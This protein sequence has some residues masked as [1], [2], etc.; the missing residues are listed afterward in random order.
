MNGESSRQP[1]PVTP[2]DRPEQIQC[3]TCAV[4]VVLAAHGSAEHSP[5]RRIGERTIFRRDREWKRRPTS[6]RRTPF[7]APGR[8]SSAT[9]RPVELAPSGAPFSVLYAVISAVTGTAATELNLPP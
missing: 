2:A 7:L 9:V 3:P 8:P 4:C 1:A 6:L 5:W